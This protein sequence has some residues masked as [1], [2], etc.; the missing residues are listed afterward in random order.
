MSIIAKRIREMREKIGLNQEELAALVGVS[1]NTVW[2]W[3]NGK[4]E[5]RSTEINKLA[6]VLGVSVSYLMGE[7]DVNH[8]NIK[9]GSFQSVIE[10]PILDPALMACAGEGN[11][12][13]N[14]YAKVDKTIYL[15]T[16]DIGVISTDMDKRPF[17]VVV[18]GD[19]MEN[20]GIPDKSVVVINPAE[21]IYDGDIVL[22]AFGITTQIAIKWIFFK[23]DG[24]I[25]LRAADPAYPPLIFTKEDIENDMVKILGKVVCVINKPRRGV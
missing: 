11:H 19:S 20:A 17:A 8:E 22:I 7:T 12:M 18:D 2:N 25:E 6:E 3:E 24:S 14:I 10:V 15:P 9:K 5:P 23:R 16:S 21:E 4:R 13:E 1:K